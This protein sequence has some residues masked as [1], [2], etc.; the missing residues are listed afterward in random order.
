MEQIV[1]RDDYLIGIDYL[2]KEHK[3]LFSTMDKL[4]KISQDPDKSE[5]AC[6]QGAK[7]L[8]NHTLEHFEHEENYMKSI[9]YSEYDLHKRLHDDFRYETLPA[10][11]EEMLE[12]NYSIESIRHFLGVCIGWVVSHTQTEDMA[13]AGKS[14]SKWADIPHEQENSALE[15]VIIQLTYDMFRMNTKMISE[16]YSGE[17]FGKM[18]CNRFIYQGTQENKW[19]ITLIFEEELLLKVIG[20]LLNTRYKKIDDMIININR[21]ISRQFLE[22]I[23]ELIPSIDLI[24]LK[25]EGLLTY[26]QLVK[27]FKE[28]HPPC[29]LLFDT[30]MGYFA[31]CMTNSDSVRGKITSAIND[32]NAISVIQEYLNKT[33]ESAS[34]DDT[35]TS[36]TNTDK[37]ETKKKILVVDDSDFMRS[38]IIELLGSK[39]EMREAPSSISAIKTLTVDRP[40]LILLDYEMPVCDGRQ[41]LEMIRSDRETADIPVIFLTG[42]GDRES[43]EKV[44]ELKPER[45]L[46]KT[47]SDEKIKKSIESF[48]EKKKK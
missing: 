11:E 28:T 35:N 17:Q 30:G 46:L 25:K 34:E 1:W 5:W 8:K 33:E 20:Q 44:M 40:D 32:K 41:A 15:Q 3:Q 38:R 19:E 14:K 36:D 47:M 12:T 26:E 7:F 31:F 48:F 2:D 45:Y 23:S 42:K 22:R 16:Q 37:A 21:Y 9:N 13:I 18:I 24:K 27:S 10:L 39:Y 6:Q 29:S 43:V 4:L